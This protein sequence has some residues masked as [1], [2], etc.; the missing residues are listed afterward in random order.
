MTAAPVRSL[1]V[2][3]PAAVP[4]AGETDTV[5]VLTADGELFCSDLHRL[6][7]LVERLTHFVGVDRPVPPAPP[8]PEGRTLRL[9]RLVVEP[10]AYAA[11]VGGRRAALTAREFELLL[12]LAR[13][14]GRTLT[15][16]EL[17]AAVWPS[18]TPGESKRTIDVHVTRLR[19]KLG[20]AAVQ[21]V[22]VRGVGYRL[23]PA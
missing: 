13:A 9:G 12:T 14:A 11:V 20:P 7:E 10:G 5:L 19:R 1:P 6:P 2:R 21:L 17:L 23:E 4:R 8:S 15:R 3:R 18:S 16:T 22:T